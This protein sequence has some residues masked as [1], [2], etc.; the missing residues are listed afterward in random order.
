MKDRLCA[1]CD[2]PFMGD[3]KVY[4]CRYCKWTTKD[5]REFER[6]FNDE[7]MTEAILEQAARTLKLNQR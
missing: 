2:L 6:F 7:V 3:D 4:I 5:P 1:N